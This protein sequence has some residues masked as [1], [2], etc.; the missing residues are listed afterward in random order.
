MAGFVFASLLIGFGNGFGSG[1]NMTIGTDLA[2]SGAVSEF[3]GAW[4]LFGD[5][6][7]SAGPAIVGAIAAAGGLPTAVITTAVLGFLGLAVL[8]LGPETLHLAE[9]SEPTE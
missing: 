8:L 6:G 2:P 3:L 7:S 5:A 1:I 4:R 9:R